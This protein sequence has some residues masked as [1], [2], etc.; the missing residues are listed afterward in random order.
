MTQEMTTKF[1][2]LVTGEDIVANC[3]IDNETQYVDVES[4]M[5][6]IIS[7]FNNSKKSILIMMPWLPLEVIDDEYATLKFEDIL[8]I[9]DPKEAFIEYYNNTVDKYRKLVE[10]NDQDEMFTNELEDD[11]FEDEITDEEVA[12]HDELA[13]EEVLESIN[14]TSTKKV[15]H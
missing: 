11:F 7:R 12:E 6:V 5:K 3:L 15:L 14:G 1:I 8:T 4:P 10:S 9:V 13:L 2:R